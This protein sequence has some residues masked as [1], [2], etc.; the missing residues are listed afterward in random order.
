MKGLS[1][2]IAT[3]ILIVIVVSIAAIIT[4]F[5]TFL[6]RETEERVTNRTTKSLDCSGG[7]IRIREV[8]LSP[9]NFSR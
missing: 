9:G 6:T 3:V 7:E 1:P 4:N 8:Y 2:L 5:A